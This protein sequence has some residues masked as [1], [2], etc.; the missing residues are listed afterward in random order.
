MLKERV[1][2]YLE[3]SGIPKTLLCRRLKISTMTLYN[4]LNDTANISEN[5]ENRIKEYLDKFE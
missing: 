4:L 1:E 5:L 2:K 3:K